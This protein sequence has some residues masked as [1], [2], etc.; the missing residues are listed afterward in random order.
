LAHTEPKVRLCGTKCKRGWLT[1]LHLDT[2]AQMIAL[3]RAMWRAFT[4]A[5]TDRFCKIAGRGTLRTTA[6]AGGVPFQP[7][8]LR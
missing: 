8:D 4:R 1:C 3:L 7:L 5:P 6:T 2:Q